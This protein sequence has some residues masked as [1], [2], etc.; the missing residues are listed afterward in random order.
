MV[1]AVVSSRAR[2]ALITACAGYREGDNNEVLVQLLK[3][4]GVITALPLPEGSAHAEMVA[5]GLQQRATLPERQASLPFL[6]A[7]PKEVQQLT[8]LNSIVPV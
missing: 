4:A 3:L 2:N 8:R 1:S 6:E 7:R 5:A